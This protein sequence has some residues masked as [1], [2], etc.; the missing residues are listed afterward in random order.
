MDGIAAVLRRFPPGNFAGAQAAR[1]VARLPPR[2][3]GPVA[4]PGDGAAHCRDDDRRNAVL[5]S[6][7]IRGGAVSAL[8]VIARSQRARAKSRGPMTGSATKQSRTAAPGWVA[9][10]R[11]Q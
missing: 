7:A 11:S 4:R 2:P 9:S 3:L 10:L 8:A 1:P 6:G 5:R